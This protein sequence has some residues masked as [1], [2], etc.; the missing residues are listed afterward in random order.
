VEVDLSRSKVEVEARWPKQ[1]KARW[2]KQIKARWPKQIKA[3]R[4]KKV[5]ISTPFI[6][7]NISPFFNLYLSYQILV[8]FF[9]T[10]SS[11]FFLL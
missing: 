6:G 10:I 5:D 4:N 7:A 11:R 1:I 3:R 9:D 2:P 8:F